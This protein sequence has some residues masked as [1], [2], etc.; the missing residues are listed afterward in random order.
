MR[1]AHFVSAFPVL[2]ETFVLDEIEA[3]AKEGFEN[4]IVSLR[5][6][7]RN[8]K[9]VE[10][11][12]RI[13]GHRSRES[14]GVA[15]VLDPLLSL[16]APFRCFA[17]SPR[18]TIAVKASLGWACLRHPRE[19]IQMGYVLWRVMEAAPALKKLGVR[20]C[21]A[22]FAHYPAAMAWGCS[23]LMGATFSW[24][25]HGYDLFSYHAQ[26][27]TRIRKADAVFPISA[28]NRDTILEKSIGCPGVEEKVSVIHCGI[29]LKA[30][31]CRTGT[32]ARSGS[33][34]EPL[35][36][37][38]GRLFDIK[39]FSDLIEAVALL[40]ES[41]K[42]VRAEIIGEG[43]ER[44]HLEELIS[45]KGLG[46]RVR[47]IGALP[48]KETRERQQSADV[49]VQPSR[50]GKH[51]PEGIPV[52]LMEAMALGAPVVSTRFAGIPELVE[53]G[54]TGRLVEP[55]QPSELAKAILSLIEKPER[56]ET[57]V[58]QARRKIEQEYD[59]PANYREKA[60]RIREIV[61]R[62]QI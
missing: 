23:K 46:E 31:P 18:T 26:L 60:R 10:E 58:R 30:Y 13:L 29:E 11:E 6:P 41:G 3:F 55:G 57:M 62:S 7:P 52:V 39:G 38:V 2:S 47:L 36:V 27:K 24:N 49:V 35:L 59:G 53:D 33:S 14:L 17:H 1:I 51:G 56:T 22:H 20:H 5:P 28:R 9:S 34:P 16:S 32:S 25:A 50:P 15:A 43:P 8:I 21:H 40:F 61:D 37:G 48:R 19:A 4:V 44:P 42:R 45:R 12:D 54:V